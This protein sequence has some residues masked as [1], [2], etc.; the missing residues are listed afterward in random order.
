M[1]IY[2]LSEDNVQFPPVECAEKNGLL[3]IGGDLSVQRL[4]N[5]YVNGIF[6]WYNEGDPIMW[7][8]P[9]ERFIIIPDE[10]KISHSMKKFIKKTDLRV[11]FNR[12]FSGVLHSCRVTREFNEGTWITDDMEAAY[13]RLF[14]KGLAASCEVWRDD[15]LV[16]GL[17]GV[18]LGRCFFG[19]SMFSKVTNAS[20]LAL[21]SLA[22]RLQELGFEFIDCQFH[23]NHLE[24][25]GGRFI[26]Y[27]DYKD[28]IKRGLENAG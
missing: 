2:K 22:N 23:T 9:V 20:K 12:D 8:C 15:V 19:E 1:P 25:M 11:S 13:N 4:V 10:I 26:S 21:I 18:V 3:A 27:S 28:K 24:S 5:A 7:W 14:E 17:Y 16:G 6:P